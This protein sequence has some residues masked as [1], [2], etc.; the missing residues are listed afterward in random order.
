MT[1]IFPLSAAVA[2]VLML[3]ALSSTASARPGAQGS[4]SS[5]GRVDTGNKGG[6]ARGLDRADAV[7]G[8]HGDQGRDRA[9]AN[10]GKK[11]KKKTRRERSARP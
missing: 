8:N 11:K 5:V 6:E 4:G 2:A 7:A 1:H 3:S 9:A 10:Q